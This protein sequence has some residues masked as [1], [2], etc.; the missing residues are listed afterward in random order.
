MSLNQWDKVRKFGLFQVSILPSF[1]FCAIG[2]FAI[3]G[4][5][6]IS[7][8]VFCLSWFASL[9]LMAKKVKEGQFCPNCK[10]LYHKRYF[11]FL[12]PFQEK[13]QHCGIKYGNESVQNS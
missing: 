13:C 4:D 1:L 8:V 5:F 11:I 7:S 9:M 12:N 10:E 2:W 6:L 3:F